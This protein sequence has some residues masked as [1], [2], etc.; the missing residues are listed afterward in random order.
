MGNLIVPP[1]ER[2]ITLALVFERCVFV[3][4]C[5][6][7]CVLPDQKEEREYK[8]TEERLRTICVF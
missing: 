6:C 7:V 1:L 4:V 5:V 2:S 8:P 3:C